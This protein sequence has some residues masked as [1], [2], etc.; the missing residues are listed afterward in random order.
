M[1]TI[2]RMILKLTLKCGAEEL[3][4]RVDMGDAGQD[5]AKNDVET[6]GESSSSEDVLKTVGDL[7]SFIASRTNADP[8][9]V[10][11]IHKGIF[12]RGKTG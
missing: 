6:D 5:L 8:K 11:I 4:A 1:F 10:K 2:C 12:R 7:R 9:K 3:I